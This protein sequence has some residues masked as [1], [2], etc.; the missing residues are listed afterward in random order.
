MTSVAIVG[1]GPSGVYCALMMCELL[2]NIDITIFEKDLL[3]KTLLVTGGGRCNLTYNEPDIQEFVKNYPRG[4]K[5]LHSIFSRYFIDQ[6]RDFFESIGVK[7]HVQED[8]RVFPVSNSASDMRKKLL[9]KLE[10]HKNVKI[11]KKEIKSAKTL[12]EFDKIVIATGS[13][14]G[15]ELAKAF[16][17]TITPLASALCGYITKQKLPPGVILSQPDGDVLFTHQGIS[18]PYV[19]KHSSLSAYKPFP[20]VLELDLIDYELLCE[21]I[22]KEPKKSFLNILSNFIPKSFA[23]CLTKNPDVQACH[24]KK[25]ELLSFKKL[26]LDVLSP[27]NKGETVKAGGVSLKEIDKNCC[28]KINPNLY[29]CGEILDIDGFCGGFN[30]Q[31]CWSTAAVAAQNIID[32]QVS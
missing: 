1:G 9:K 2:E 30:L 18:G 15:Y 26:S 11:I 3:L 22:K 27:D 31:N 5:F 24:I 20:F 7:T 12:E 23:K 8:N 13:K 4:E 21:A 10:K 17:H 14:G 28:S 29:F 6:T 16:G 25:E 32:S 19:Y